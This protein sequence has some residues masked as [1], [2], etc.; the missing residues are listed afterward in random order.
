[1]GSPK[2]FESM[3]DLVIRHDI[4]PIID[5]TESLENGPELIASMESMPQFG[6]LALKI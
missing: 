2:D 1:M 5:R 6:K 4:H 3:L